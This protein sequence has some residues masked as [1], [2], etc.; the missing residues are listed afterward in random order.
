MKFSDPYLRNVDKFDLLCRWIIFHSVLY[1]ELDKPIVSDEMFDNNCKQ[2][3]RG[4]KKDPESFERS[5]YYHI[6]YDFD[7]STG[8]D[9]PARLDKKTRNKIMRDIKILEGSIK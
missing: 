3:V 5:K 6:M 7:G 4:I 8:F 1:Y 2:L 9:I